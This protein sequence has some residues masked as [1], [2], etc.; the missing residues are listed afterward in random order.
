MTWL[1]AGRGGE[2]GGGGGGNNC[3][4]FPFPF[5]FFFFTP[6]SL[7]P[8]LSQVTRGSVLKGEKAEGKGQLSRRLGCCCSVLCPVGSPEA[9]SSRDVTYR[10]AIASC[11]IP[12]G[13]CIKYKAVHKECKCCHPDRFRRR[14]LRRDCYTVLPYSETSVANLGTTL[15]LQWDLRVLRWD[16]DAPCPHLHPWMVPSHLPPL[17]HPYGL[18]WSTVPND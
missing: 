15:L 2:K 9:P 10:A 8:H 17:A 1:L 4:I 14:D 11:P 6:S 12:T 5:F 13:Q 18:A 3:T 16:M 7:F